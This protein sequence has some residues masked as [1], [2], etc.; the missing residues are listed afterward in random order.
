M[1]F[2]HYLMGFSTLALSAIAWGFFTGLCCNTMMASQY[3]FLLL[4]SYH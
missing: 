4:G 3:H 2:Q 1:V